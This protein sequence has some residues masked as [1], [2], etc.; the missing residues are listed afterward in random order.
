VL[1]FFMVLKFFVVALLL[2]LGLLH[3][4]VLGKLAVRIKIFS[5]KIISPSKLTMEE[6][7]HKEIYKC[8]K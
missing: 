8:I 2:N 6:I 3:A 7:S 1:F 4:T 5:S